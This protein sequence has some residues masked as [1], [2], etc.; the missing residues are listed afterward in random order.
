M[1][2]RGYE[3]DT[4][5]VIAII[6]LG[7][8]V[9]QFALAFRVTLEGLEQ[10]AA[11]SYA[12]IAAKAFNT[13]VGITLLLLGFG[14]A[15]IAAI[16]IGMA[17]I[18][19]IVTWRYLRKELNKDGVFR[20]R[21][22]WPLAKRLMRDGLPY[23][24]SSL[25]LYGYVA[26]DAI[27]MEYL[28]DESALG[29]Y[30]A[31]DRIFGTMMFVPT[32][33]ISAVFPVLSRTY[34]ND[35]K[36]L[37]RM[38]SRSFSLMALM[39]VPIGMGLVVIAQPLVLLLY[40]E[41]FAKSGLILAM[42][43][44]MIML[45]Y[46]TTLIGRFLISADRQNAWTRIMM[47]ATVATVPLDLV[48]IPFS[49]QFLDNGAVGG[50]LA[51][52]TT[53]LG[54]L[55]SGL[56]LLPRGSFTKG[57][58]WLWTKTL[59]AGGLMAGAAYI[60][61]DYFII[62]P[63][64]VGGAVYIGLVFAFNLIPETEM[65]LIYSMLP[66]RFTSRWASNQIATAAPAAPIAHPTIV[67]VTFDEYEAISRLRAEL[68][69]NSTEQF[70]KSEP[71]T[72]TLTAFSRNE[73]DYPSRYNHEEADFPQAVEP[74]M[75][76][77]SNPPSQN[78]HS[79]HESTAHGTHIGREN[80][81]VRNE[82]TDQQN[83]QASRPS[84]AKN[85]PSHGT[86]GYALPEQP[87]KKKRGWFGRNR[88]KKSKVLLSEQMSDVG[89]PLDLWDDDGHLLM[90]FS[91]EVV[92]NMR[93]TMTRLSSRTGAMPSRL[94]VVS[95]L[96]GEGVTYISRALATIMAHDLAARVCLVDLNWWA[97]A[98]PPIAPPSNLG[99]VGVVTGD[100]R[101]DQIFVRTA[102]PNLTLVPAGVLERGDRPI[103][104][105]SNVLQSAIDVLDQHF[106]YLIFDIPAIRATNDAVPLAQLA[107]GIALVIRQGVTPIESIN[108][109]I[110]EIQHLPILG[111]I[112][113]GVEYRTPASILRFIPQD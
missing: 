61:R 64:I 98:Q 49:E 40:G 107:D 73:A 95:A 82:R 9:W 65:A 28:L 36:A 76:F 62:W 15:V 97:P 59:M 45:T 54:M 83:G 81:P 51:Y 1:A 24:F 3:T 67:N 88:R 37:P 104:A 34:V 92:D 106:D 100:V 72:Q 17:I 91:A 102:L 90:R 57:N 80:N 20:W 94:G 74:S 5:L 39:S 23:M 109:G 38:M 31:A 53:E 43:G 29:L 71:V 89:E 78:G 70:V 46:Q 86:N 96:P 66:K 85:H 111:A 99:L 21:F 58:A 48:L 4:V 8:F 47:V 13:F 110:D 77:R 18:Y 113:N 2:L 26:V 108:S 55:A 68:A 63:L 93:T 35:P 87:K 112:M 30:S 14:V 33:F 42:F 41:D 105:R 84:S 32:A 103:M 69:E 12:E 52:L 75:T 50:V 19:T 27:I 56:Y 44:V 10:M 101:L 79:S 60:V 25:F 22:D 16:N 7:Q 11:V 6:G